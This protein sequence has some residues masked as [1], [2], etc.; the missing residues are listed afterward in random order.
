MTHFIVIYEDRLCL[1]YAKDWK[2]AIF[3]VITDFQVDGD[4]KNFKAIK[5]G[6]CTANHRTVEFK[7]VDDND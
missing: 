2:D 1:T 6:R 3:N 7:V 4:F 5:V